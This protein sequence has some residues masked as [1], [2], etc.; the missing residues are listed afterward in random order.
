MSYRDEIHCAGYESLARVNSK[1]RRQY[2]IAHHSRG[3]GQRMYLC[4]CMKDIFIGGKRKGLF[5]QF[6]RKEIRRSKYNIKLKD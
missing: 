3:R 6:G 4:G 5:T 1:T 2:H